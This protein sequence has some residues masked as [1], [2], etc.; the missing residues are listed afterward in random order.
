MIKTKNTITIDQLECDFSA[1]RIPIE[2]L[3]MDDLKLMK[4]DWHL[5]EP[6]EWQH[7]R[8]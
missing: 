6:G 4:E 1:E 3:S 7:S 2:K 5:A 8:G